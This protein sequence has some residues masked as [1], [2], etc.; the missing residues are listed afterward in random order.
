M[1]RLT[2]LGA[3]DLRDRHGRAIRDV[4][5][6]PKRAALLVYLA[7]EGRKAP[8]SRDRLV[9]LFWPES[10]SAHARNTLSQ[11]LHHL[12]QAL[13]AEFLENVGTAAVQVRTDALWCDATVFADALERGEAELALDLYRGDFC[14]TLFVSGAPAVEEWVEEQRARLRRHALSAART[15]AERLASQGD[16]AGALRTARRA[17]ALRPDDEADVRAMLTLLERLGDAAGAL[18][19]YQEWARRLKQEL[20]VEPAP[21]T[22]L[23]VDA[24]R[25]RREP[26]AGT[27]P[28]AT[29]RPSTPPPAAS[30]RPRSRRLEIAVAAAGALMLVTVGL[31]AR[32]TRPHP[33]IRAT[34][35]AV[36][37]FEV[38]GGAQHA[39]LREGMVDL[40]SVDLDGVSEVQ[41]IDP[42]SVLSAARHDPA[43]SPAGIAQRLGAGRYVTGEIVEAGGRLQVTATI[44]D[45]R[46]ERRLASATM[47]GDSVSIFTLV[48]GLAARLLSAMTGARDTT[49]AHLAAV[50]THSLPALKAFLAGERALRTGRDYAAAAAYREA[51]TLDT[52]FALAQYRLAVMA[53]WVIVR[54]VG[55]PEAVQR[56]S[57]LAARNAQ[58]LPPLARDLLTAY[59]AYKRND[60]TTAERIY[61]GVTS[62][63]PDNTEAWF[64]LGET[65]FHY[66]AFLGRSPL[67]SEP[68]FRRVLDLDAG[69][70]HAILHLARLAALYGRTAMLDSLAQQYAQLHPEAGRSLEVRALTAFSRDSA[71]WM[72]IARDAT[73]ADDREVSSILIAAGAY[74]ENAAAARALVPALTAATRDSTA[75]FPMGNE[76]SIL[77]LSQGIWRDPDWLPPRLLHPDWLLEARVLVAAEPMMGLSRGRIVALRALLA[78]RRRWLPQAS[79]P[80]ARP[81]VPLGESMRAYLLGLLS[82]RLGDTSDVATQLAALEGHVALAPASRALALALRGAAARARGDTAAALAALQAFPLNPILGPGAVVAHWG[83]AERFAHAE[84]L[85]AR[86]Q[87]ADAAMLYDSFHSL[88]DLPFAAASHLRLGEIM[89]RRGDLPSARFHYGRVI[90]W[91]QDP[92]SEFRPL[93]DRARAA[94]TR[95]QSRRS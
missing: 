63:H 40:L 60:G 42:A 7:I 78:G 79:L 1:L 34:A 48:D 23:V 89:E 16:A 66:N 49:F 68:A 26:A 82:A 27:A 56:W 47:T 29:P 46:R 21:E 18:G 55:D 88:Y 32:S 70:T 75:M 65:L 67:E 22:R 52:T 69:N 3:T 35:I 13:G 77:D 76:L 94:L 72:A 43:A 64:M 71:A 39:Y 45:A 80:V 10:D 8:V 87:D 33:A 41:A 91:Y 9:A 86:G 24:I 17:L 28:A 4:L 62:S 51:A 50:S 36:F 15:L 11:S 31:L 38:H 44:F 58:R 20:D 54:D 12:R 92:D 53:T 93:R 30:A 61:R 14:P 5:K 74:A 2:T 81:D 90:A 95:I 59:A 25:R 37:P 19:A 84:L 6:Q 83:V 85:L 57:D 73:N